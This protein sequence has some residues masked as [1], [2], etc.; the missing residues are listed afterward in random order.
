MRPGPQ[1][2][3]RSVHAY[4]CFC[5]R[6]ARRVGGNE[7][8]SILHPLH[9]R[10]ARHAVDR[11]EHLVCV[12]ARIFGDGMEEADVRLR[13]HEIAGACRDNPPRAGRLETVRAGVAERAVDRDTPAAEQLCGGKADRQL[14][15]GLPH[16]AERRRSRPVAA[17]C[18]QRR[19]EAPAKS[20]RASLLRTRCPPSRT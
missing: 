9:P 5:R 1:S 3:L 14:A 8:P 12:E 19:V 7:Q 4:C 6:S 20:S 2:G 15:A 13:I 16:E 10:Q 11:R 18:R 17:A